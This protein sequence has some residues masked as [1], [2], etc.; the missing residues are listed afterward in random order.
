MPIKPIE[1]DKSHLSITIIKYEDVRKIIDEIVKTVSEELV[2]QPE[3]VVFGKVCNQNRD[4]GFYSNKSK[5][6]AYS[7]QLMESKPLIDSMENLIIYVNTYYNTNFNSLLINKYNNGTEYI[8]A[9]SDD[10]S[11]L[12]NDG[13]VTISYGATRKFRIRDKTTKKIVQDIKTI[14]YSM[15]HM[16]GDFQKE[17]THEIPI[18]KKVKD[19]R[20]SITF[21]N[22]KE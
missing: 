4:V 13:V 5:G 14:P 15:I 19:T 11:G 20:V 1:T 21:R 22:H 17:F 12:A 16:A 7:N 2:V 10:E 9:H 8:G 6:Y 3:I 18:E